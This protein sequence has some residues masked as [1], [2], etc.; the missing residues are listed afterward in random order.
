MEQ[1][2]E[3]VQPD[4]IGVVNYADL[5]ILAESYMRTFNGAPWFDRWDRETA[6]LRIM[7]LYRTPGFYGLSLWQDGMPLGTVLGRSERYFDGDCFQIVEFW[8]EPRMQKMGYGK[9]LMD[10]LTENLRQF[11]IKKVYLIT[12]RSEQ[13]QRFY[14]KNGFVVQDGLCVMQLPEL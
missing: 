11:G 6:L 5:T 1:K 4:G 14:E 9:Q 2:P 8:V 7:D 10:N 3:D 13:T 12:M